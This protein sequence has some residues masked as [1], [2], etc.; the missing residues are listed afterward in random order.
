VVPVPSVVTAEPP[1]LGTVVTFEDPAG[2]LVAGDDVA[3]GLLDVAGVLWV[4]VALWAGSAL[5][6]FLAV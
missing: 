3:G 5:V 2:G 1:E 4:V 6:A